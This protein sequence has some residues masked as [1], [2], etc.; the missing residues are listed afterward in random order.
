MLSVVSEQLQGELGVLDVAVRQQQQVPGA[1]GR[2][3]EAEGPQGPPQL[4]AASYWPGVLMGGSGQSKKLSF[5]L[6]L[7]PNYMHCI[8][9]VIVYSSLS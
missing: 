4:S 8:S 3:Q 1:A 6:S 7:L 9:I 5:T 2:R